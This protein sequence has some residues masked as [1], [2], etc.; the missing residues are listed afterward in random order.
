VDLLRRA[1][2]QRQASELSRPISS[3]KGR[4]A[5]KVI[6]KDGCFLLVFFGEE[7]PFFEELDVL[8]GRLFLQLGS[9]SLNLNSI[10]C[11]ENLTKTFKF[12][13]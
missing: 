6:D 3:Y 7:S 9:L 4:T 8:S 2:Q 13:I 11:Q 10:L 5:I 1:L 12:L